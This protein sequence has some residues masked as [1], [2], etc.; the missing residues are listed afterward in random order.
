M[1]AGDSIALRLTRL[2]RL[3]KA[4]GFSDAA[5]Q[6]LIIGEVELLLTLL[7]SLPEADQQDLRAA[8][9]SL[10]V[11]P[12]RRATQERRREQAIGVEMERRRGPDRRRDRPIS[13][14]LGNP[15][16]DEEEA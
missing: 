8:L 13:E 7:P 15:D 12:D 16:E 4:E 14:W 6:D 3:L 9:Y 2:Q 11:L 10:G 5:K 1:R